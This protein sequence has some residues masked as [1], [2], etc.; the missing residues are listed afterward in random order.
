MEEKR[1]RKT[2]KIN[3]QDAIFEPF[4][5]QIHQVFTLEWEEIKDEKRA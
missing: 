5:F 1:Q 3:G 2:R 4:D